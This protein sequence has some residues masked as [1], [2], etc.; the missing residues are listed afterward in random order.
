MKGNK[1]AVAGYRKQQG[2]VLILVTMGM[3]V[4]VGFA[5]LAIDINHALLNHS[6]L[7]NAVDAAALAAAM[8]A[9]KFN[10]EDKGTEA[11]IETFNHITSSSGN[12][13]MV[14]DFN[15][16]S[17]HFDYS[18]D[19]EVFPDNTFTNTE[20]I[21]VRV[22]VTSYSLTSYFLKVFGID[23]SI[24]ASAVAGEGPPANKICNIVPM[25]VCKGGE[26]D[27]SDNNWGYDSEAIVGLK[28]PESINSP[29]GPG[30][31]QLL[32]FGSGGADVR[33]YM[34]GSY[35]ECVTLGADVTTKPGGT[36]G[37]VGQGLNTRFGDYA[38][39]LSRDDHRPDDFIGEPPVDII[40]NDDG[41]AVNPDGNWAGINAYIDGVTYCSSASPDDALCG[42]SITT[43]ETDR[44]K[45]A[46]PIIDCTGAE[47]GVNQLPVE[48]VGCFILVQ[49][50][51]T[52]NGGKQHV[53]GQFEKDCTEENS[54]SDDDG[55]GDEGIYRIVLYNDPLS[56]GS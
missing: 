39:G 52:S 40:I 46:V 10:D 5:A 1:Y 27:S 2:L 17:I 14:F 48:G 20:D 26:G 23:K 9:D 18:N 29:M 50:A 30:N 8:T 12:S 31:F 16:N 13:S 49:K 33:E 37:P 21:Y 15:S 6:K 25:A 11:A 56:E 42:K 3:T 53:I 7:Q 32:D 24:K 54:Y 55:S 4:L 34:A 22:S 28:L 44:R 43:P 35:A 19:P 41:T 36:I 47:G 38:A 45:L 51:P